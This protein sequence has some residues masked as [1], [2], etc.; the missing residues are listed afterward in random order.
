LARDVVRHVGDAVAFVV[1]E[2]VEQ[3]RDAAEAITIEWEP[4]PAVIGAATALAPDAPR[5]WPDR[6]DNLV[7]E[8][9]LGD[10]K[11]TAD[12][13][14]NAARTVSL[15]IVNQRLVANYLDTRG[16]V[17]EYETAA[18]RLTLTLSSQGSH[19]VRDVLCN[20]VLKIAPEKL[21]VVTPD[22]GG[23]FGTKL[24]CYR[25]YALAAVAAKT[26]GRP[27]KWV[28]DRS[29]HFLGDSQGRDNVTTARL[30]LDASN[31]F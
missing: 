16:V 17:A 8:T 14:A 27:V 19:L 1:A 13:F 28:A 10:A 24:F 4:L 29:D 30:A 31:R 6:R 5:V 25:E 11:S 26:L 12:A 22:V 18:D 9:T 23:G 7:F 3:A 2:T 21:R 15:A 20:D